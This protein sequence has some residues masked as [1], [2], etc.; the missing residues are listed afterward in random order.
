MFEKITNELKKIIMKLRIIIGL[1]T[2]LALIIYFTP[3]GDIFN[4]QIKK[5]VE[6]F[7]EETKEKIE[8][9]KEDVEKDIKKVEDKVNKNIKKVE[10]KF[11]SL[12]K[13][14]K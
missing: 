10:D 9:K 1:S 6:E 3:L 5:K 4:G 8:E 13:E 12:I 14:F 2:V 7:K 11:K